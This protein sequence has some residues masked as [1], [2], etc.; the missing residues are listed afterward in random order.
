MGLLWY[1]LEGGE[2]RKQFPS[3]SWEGG[4]LQPKFFFHRYLF[5]TKLNDTLVW[6]EDPNSRL[7]GFPEFADLPDFLSSTDCNTRF[8]HIEAWTISCSIVRIILQPPR[9]RCIFDYPSGFYARFA[10]NDTSVGFIK[11]HLSTRI[12]LADWNT[13]GSTQ[14][15]YMGILLPC[16]ISWGRSHYP[17]AHVLV[18]E[19]RDE[20]Y[21]RVG[22]FYI[23]CYWGDMYG[24]L[25]A[26]LQSDA[27]GDARETVDIEALKQ[28]CETAP[29]TR[30]KIR[31]G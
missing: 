30:R 19:D 29:K 6:V 24:G 22:C 5:N 7:Q 17:R 16:S 13:L 25:D 31:L 9:K 3:W 18:V 28:W 1:H 8:I 12:P 11:L 27:G 10:I 14:K 21:E 2:R 15:T 26:I 4:K 23:Y 20:Y